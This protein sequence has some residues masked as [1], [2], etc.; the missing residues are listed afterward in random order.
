MAITGG[1]Q[2]IGLETAHQAVRRSARVAL[3]DIHSEAVARAAAELGDEKVALGLTADVRDVTSLQRALS[4]K[5]ERFGGYE[6]VIVNAGIGAGMRAFR[7]TSPTDFQ[8]II[9][10]NLHGAIRTVRASLN[11]VVG[12][13]G[14][15]VLIS[16]VLAFNNGVLQS[17]YAASKAG[18]GG[19]GGLSHTAWLPGHRN[20]AAP[21]RSGHLIIRSHPTRADR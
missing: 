14:H 11:Q 4:E 12:L 5:S 19:P 20:P 6:T 16:A 13:Q 1:A 15:Y 3:L 10:V 9:D 2:G 7:A 8:R 21:R 17:P 18:T